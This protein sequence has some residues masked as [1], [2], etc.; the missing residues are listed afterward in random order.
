M[1][2]SAAE[3]RLGV[4]LVRP[5]QFAPH[6]PADPQQQHT[7]GKQQPD[8]RQQLNGDAREQDAQHGCGDDPNQNRARAPFFGQAGRRQADDDRIVARQ[9]QVD[10]DDLEKGGD[11]TLR[12]NLGHG[13]R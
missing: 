2:T 9:H 11:R 4:A 3:C 13:L 10:H 12:E 1:D 5:A 8:D 7:A 6:L